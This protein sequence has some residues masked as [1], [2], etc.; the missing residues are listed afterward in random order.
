MVYVGPV[1]DARKQHRTY[2]AAIRSWEKFSGGFDYR[3]AQISLYRSIRELLDTSIDQK[4]GSDDAST[5]ARRQLPSYST[6]NAQLVSKADWDRGGMSY[7]ALDDV[8]PSLRQNV[9]DSVVELGE[10]LRSDLLKQQLANGRGYDSQLDVLRAVTSD[11]GKSR[12]GQNL[13]ADLQL[14]D[15]VLDPEHLF[16][17]PIGTNQPNVP[18]RLTQDEANYFFPGGS[19]DR[20]KLKSDSTVGSVAQKLIGLAATMTP[21]Y[22]VHYARSQDLTKPAVAFSRLSQLFLPGGSFDFDGLETSP[23]GTRLMNLRA[24]IEQEVNSLGS[25]TVGVWVGGLKAIGDVISGFVKAVEFYDNPSIENGVDAAAGLTGAFFSIAQHIDD[26]AN[27]GRMSVPKNTRVKVYGMYAA[28][29]LG[30]LD[31]VASAT[32][33]YDSYTTGDY[34]VAAGEVLSTIGA[35]AL[36]AHDLA[37]AATLAVTGSAAA[38]SAWFTGGVTLLVFI[39]FVIATQSADS[40][41]ESWLQNCYYGT[42]YVGNSS[43]WDDPTKPYYRWG[44]TGSFT[45]RFTRPVS[46]YRSMLGGLKLHDVVVRTVEDRRDDSNDAVM[47]KFDGADYDDWAHAAVL[48]E[49]DAFQRDSLVVVK[50]IYKE[51]TSDYEIHPLYYDALGKEGD[52]SDVHSV[53]P[54]TDSPNIGRVQRYTAA[55]NDTRYWRLEIGAPDVELLFDI[56]ESIYGDNEVGSEVTAL[57]VDVVPNGL[58]PSVIGSRNLSAAD[59]NT[60]E[61]IVQRARATLTEDIW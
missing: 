6:L 10:T 50:L 45:E 12:S 34:S 22:A 30:A 7:E 19:F 13:L 4:W 24:H 42:N 51:E 61:L 46:D 29:V 26:L 3:P 38:A 5:E 52:V 36:L 28:P 48:L 15:E 35:T 40:R 11:L 43:N 8:V 23:S 2:R 14:P 54:P 16:T 53:R 1:D 27:S 32:N 59:L 57:E 44:G 56:S 39:G 49:I 17:P 41:V 60:N 21:G 18:V 20:A 58:H 33:G 47:D 55:S 31:V 25:S 37:A 9:E